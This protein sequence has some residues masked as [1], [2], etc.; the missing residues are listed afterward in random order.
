VLLVQPN[1]AVAWTVPGGT[2]AGHETPQ[3]ALS[4]VLV[5]LTGVVPI[6]GALQHMA[7]QEHAS[8]I[9]LEL[10]LTITNGVAFSNIDMDHIARTNPMIDEIG[11][12]RP[13]SVDMQPE[14]L[15]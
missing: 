4:R 9:S 11:F 10:Y 3:Q 15:R 5:E 7:Q 6:V 2:I 14:F 13:G 8:G 12:M 1:D